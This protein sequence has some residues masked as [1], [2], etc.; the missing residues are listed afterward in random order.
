MLLGVHKDS[1]SK[2]SVFSEAY[3]PDVRFFKTLQLDEARE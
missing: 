1:S 3:L 2:R